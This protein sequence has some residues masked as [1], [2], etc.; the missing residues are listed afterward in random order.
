MR[1]ERLFQDLEDQLERETDAELEDLTRDEERRRLSRLTMRD[2]LQDLVVS[3]TDINASTASPLRDVHGSVLVDLRNGALE[4][5]VLRVGSDWILVQIKTPHVKAGTALIPLG[6]IRS[7]EP[8]P[9]NANPEPQTRTAPRASSSSGL[10]SEIGIAFVLR[11]LCRRRRQVSLWIDSDE[12]TGTIERVGKD[13]VTVSRDVVPRSTSPEKARR[14]VT[15]AFHFI[16][17]I[18]LA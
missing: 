4:C 12:I 7:F 2:W 14:L 18:V 3:S 9:S 5:R 1:W 11:D 10:T 17:V 16:D 6:S 13:H 15:A 8:L